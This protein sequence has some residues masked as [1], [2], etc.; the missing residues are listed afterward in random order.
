MKLT[1]FYRD[2]I[3]ETL[4]S[5]LSLALGGSDAVTKVFIAMLWLRFSFLQ[6]NLEAD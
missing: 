5:K 6:R 1:K 2:T 3:K 4:E